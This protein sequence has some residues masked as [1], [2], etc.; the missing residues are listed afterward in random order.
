MNEAPFCDFLGVTVP[1]DEWDG[2]R[3][4]IAAELDAIGMSVEVD[5]ERMVLWRSPNAR[6]TV[7]AKRVGLVWALGCSGAVCASLRLG[8]RFNAYLAAI[9]SR[10]HRVT[11]ID[12]SVDYAVDAAPI[13]AAVATAGQNGELSLTRKR[14]RPSDVETH[15]G[16]RADG[17]RTGTVYLGAKNADVRM[18]VYDKQ[19]ERMHKWGL[20]DTGPLTRYELRLRAGTGITLRDAAEPAAVFWNYASPDFLPTPP[21]TPAWVSGGTG[22]YLEPHIPLLPAQRL[23]RRVESSRDLAALVGLANQCGPFGV[24]LLCHWIGEMG[25][26]QGRAPAETAPEGL[27]AVLDAMDAPALTPRRDTATAH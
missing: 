10:R 17:A 7:N 18:M 14:I 26:V 11:R 20:P 1:A 16:V 4:D 22:Y 25:G 13:V 3:L 12:A 24:R 6:G 8:G 5:E 2:L 9:G 21:G 23:K 19:H 27:H 15:I